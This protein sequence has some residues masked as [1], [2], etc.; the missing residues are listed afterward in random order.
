MTTFDYA[1]SK[2]TAT[3]MIT[4][5]GQ[6]VTLTHHSIGAY[7]PA[8]GT[9]TDTTSTQTGVGAIFEWGQQGSTPSYGK[10]MIDKS[11]IIEGDKQLYLSATSITMPSIND[12]VTDANGKVY[13]IKMI[14][15]LA[16]S[17]TAVLY[18]VNI[19]GI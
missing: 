2:A 16:P 18:E 1:I 14:K 19:S 8:T 3:R 10:S 12:N 9:A 7:D 6:S 11:L 4:R 17:G 13:T 5:H 15:E